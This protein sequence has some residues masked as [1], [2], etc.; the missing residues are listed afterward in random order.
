MKTDYRLAL[1]IPAMVVL[2][3]VGGY[4]ALVL[5]GLP[6]E[7]AFNSTTV[8]LVIG[9]VAILRGIRR[10]PQKTWSLELGGLL[11]VLVAVAA[12]ALR[13]IS[14]AS[15]GG[16]LFYFTVVSSGGLAFVARR[17]VQRMARKAASAADQQPAPQPDA[18][19]LD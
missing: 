12:L 14:L 8:A 17:M 9:V 13:A 6:R 10:A 4:G 19:P 1:G 16:P 11:A 18:P 5:A 3:S 2:A 7:L 15:S